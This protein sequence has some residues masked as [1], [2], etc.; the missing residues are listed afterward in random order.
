MIKLSNLIDLFINDCLFETRFS[1]KTHKYLN[2]SAPIIICIQIEKQ[3]QLRCRLSICLFLFQLVAASD[4]TG[5]IFKV[6]RENFNTREH[7]SYMEYISFHAWPLHEFTMEV[8]GASIALSQ[9]WTCV[10]LNYLLVLFSLLTQ[11]KH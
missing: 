10:I 9:V 2:N 4:V 8:H 11:Y 7:L 3:K 5:C 6:Q 1:T